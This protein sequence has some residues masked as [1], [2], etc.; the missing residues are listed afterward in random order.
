[1]TNDRDK[2]KALWQSMPPEPIQISQSQ[3]QKRTEKFQLR[4]KWRDKI[5]YLGWA[6]LL[7]LLGFVAYHRF[8]V[9][10]AIYMGLALFAAAICAWNYSRFARVNT[11]NSVSAD[12]S[13]LDY[14]KRELV[15]QRDAA[16][17]AWKWYIMPMMPFFL[18]TFAFRWIEEGASLT[19]INEFRLFIIAAA[20]AIFL[21]IG[22]YILWQ[23]LKAA[24]YQRS[25]DELERIT[26]G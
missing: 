21:F 23:F 25:L 22:G 20:V 8:D 3:L 18:Y 16:A 4:H 14:M 7:P 19:E 11:R 17:T 26:L 6:A 10:I 12:L 5:E 2:L 1:M 9:R 24:R 13:T 15:R